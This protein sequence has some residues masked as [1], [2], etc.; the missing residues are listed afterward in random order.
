MNTIFYRLTCWRLHVGN[1]T[2]WLILS[3]VFWK[4]KEEQK[5]EGVNLKNVFDNCNPITVFK[6]GTSG[7]NP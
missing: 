2:R 4:N 6:N 7:D 1:V 5:L 3:A